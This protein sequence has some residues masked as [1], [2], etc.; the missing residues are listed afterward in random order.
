MDT[1]E[2]LQH[3]LEFIDEHITDNINPDI[4]AAHAGYSTWHFCRVFQWGTGY[5]VM[6]YVRNRRLAFAAHELS[7]G[8]RILD[9]SM[10]YG[11]ETHSGFSKAFR[12]YFGCSPGTYRLHAHCDRPFPPSLPGTYKYLIGGIIMEPRFVTLP[13]I[14]LA[15]F[16]IK[17]TST[18]GENSKTIPAFWNDYMSGGMMEKLH[19]ENFIKKHD[20]YGV[21]FQEDPTTGEFE[22]VIGVERIDGTEIPGEY[23]VCEVPP[24]TYAVFSSPPSDAPNFVAAIQGTWNYIFNEWFPKSGYEYA[25]DCNDF[26]LYDDRSMPDEGKICDIYIPVVKMQK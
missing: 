11:F 7:S 3:I 10:E 2:T 26:E 12:R 24:A 19:A 18:A 9:I 15:G 21:C 16:A 22:Y 6:A 5:S 4:L 13:S 14:K 17:T 8:K 25:P 20:E 1:M 23:H